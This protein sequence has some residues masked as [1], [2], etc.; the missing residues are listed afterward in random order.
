MKFLVDWG[1][2]QDRGAFP[3]HFW[4][5]LEYM[6]RN[7]QDRGRWYIFQLREES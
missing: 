7:I 6:S 4:L 1:L 5:S 2:Y 3:G